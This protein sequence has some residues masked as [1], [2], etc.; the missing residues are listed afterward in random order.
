VADW[1]RQDPEASAAVMQGLFFARVAPPKSVRQTLTPPRIVF[2]HPS[3]PVHPWSDSDELV[4][5]LPNAR[6]V[7]ASSIL[8]G[9][10]QPK[11]LS[12]EIAEFVDECFLDAGLTVPEPTGRAA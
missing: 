12:G 5:E 2:G 3:D 8:E 6:L 7:R 11:R 4:R 10:L 9:R 1:V